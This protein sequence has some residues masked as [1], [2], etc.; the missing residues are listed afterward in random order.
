VPTSSTPSPAAGT[1]P[2]VEQLPSD[3]TQVNVMPGFGNIVQVAIHSASGM[4]EAMP[5]AVAAVTIYGDGRIEYHPIA[6][7]DGGAR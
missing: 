3:V 4:P 7:A 5:G 2:L 6:P 1:S